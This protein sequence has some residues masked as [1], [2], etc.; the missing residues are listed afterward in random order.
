VPGDERDRAGVQAVR[1]GQFEVRPGRDRRG[2]TRHDLV[3]ETRG[4]KRLGFFAPAAEDQRVAA[5]E[6][7]DGLAGRCG[8]NELEVDV[9]V[10]V[11]VLAGQVAHAHALR[12]RRGEVEQP[13]R[14]ELVVQHEVGA[15]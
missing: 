14:H 3:T 11:G 9:R 10:L 13:L 1:Q 8:L 4:A 6:P 2:H 7:H 12:G 5:L 15:A